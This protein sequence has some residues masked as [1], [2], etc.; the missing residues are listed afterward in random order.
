[1][2][3]G[4]CGR[5]AQLK[6]HTTQQ[7]VGETIKT[8]HVNQ[9]FTLWSAHL[10]SLMSFLLQSLPY[11]QQQQNKNNSSKYGNSLSVRQGPAGNTVTHSP[12]PH[13]RRENEHGRTYTKHT[14]SHR[15]QEGEWRLH[16]GS[17]APTSQF[18]PSSS[19]SPPE[20]RGGTDRVGMVG[21]PSVAA[22]RMPRGPS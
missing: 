13:R 3:K 19:R 21:S 6:K 11:R 9:G 20:S 7:E 10:Y 18:P 8:T 14:R 17:L 16:L 4:P 5:W 2:C 15:E 22:Q 12:N 1:M